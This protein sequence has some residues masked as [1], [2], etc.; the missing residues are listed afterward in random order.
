MEKQ[1]HD[2][3]QLAATLCQMAGITQDRPAILYDVEAFE[4]FLGLRVILLVGTGK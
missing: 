2:Q 3:K 1:R 4:E